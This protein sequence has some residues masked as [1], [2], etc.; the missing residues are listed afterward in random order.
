MSL[1]K[2]KYRKKVRERLETVKKL[3]A[4]RDRVEQMMKRV[5]GF[6]EGS[7]FHN[8]M[9]ALY[10]FLDTDVPALLDALDQLAA[11]R[12]HEI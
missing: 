2:I 1:P 5:G 4:D 12:E 6:A 8:K 11:E 10:M 3:F 7:D 9:T